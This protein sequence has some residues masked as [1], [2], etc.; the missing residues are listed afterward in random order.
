MDEYIEDILEENDSASELLESLDFE[1]DDFN[2]EWLDVLQD[3]H[4][5]YNQ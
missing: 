5:L 2:K 4:Y 3:D 1:G